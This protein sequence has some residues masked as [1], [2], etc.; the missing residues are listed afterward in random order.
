M[1]GDQ[2]LGLRLCSNGGKVGAEGVDLAVVL[3]L[4]FLAAADTCGIFDL[5]Q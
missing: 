4:F 5:V 2:Q 3:L 1:G